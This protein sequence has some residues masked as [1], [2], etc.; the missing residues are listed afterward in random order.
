LTVEVHSRSRE[1]VYTNKEAGFFFTETHL[2][3]R[4][5][6]HG[7]HIYAQEI[8]E[9]YLL[10]ID[11]KVLERSSVNLTFVAPHQFTRV[12]QPGV[13]ETVTL[14][15]SLNALVVELSQL[16]G[17]LLSLSPLFRGAEDS[18][19]YVVKQAEGVLLIASRRNLESD[20]PTGVPAWI[21]ITFANTGDGSSQAVGSLSAHGAFAPAGLQTTLDGRTA[22]VLLVAGSSEAETL[23]LARSVRETHSDLI[24]RRAKRME[25]HLNNTFIRTDHP[26]FDKALHWAILS[27]DA[28][29]MNQTKKGIFAGLPWFNNYWGRDSFI[30]LPGATLVTG[31]FS[32]AKA[33][34]RSFAEWQEV[35]PKSKNYGR[36]PNLVTTLSKS[37]NTADGTA[38]F[39]IALLEYVK[40]SGDLTFA[41]SLFSVVSRAIEGALVHRVDSYGFLTHEDAETWMDAV[42]PEGPWSPRGN[43]AN[44]IQAL[45]HQQ[46]GSGIA[47]ARLMGDSASVT[48]WEFA[49]QKVEAHFNQRFVDRMRGFVY[50]HINIDGSPDHQ[51][52]PNQLFTLQLIDD[53]EVRWKVFRN[54]TQELVYP[55]GVASL[56]QNDE[57]FHPYHHYRPYYVQDAAYHNG[58]VWTW[59]AGPWISHACRF[60]LPDLAFEVTANMVT[61]MLD[62]GAVGTLSELLDAAP[63]PGEHEP[64]LSGTASQAWSLAEFIRSFYQDYLGV[65]TD[66]WE[67]TIHISP[68]LPSTF[69]SVRFRI[70]YKEN[71]I[72][73]FINQNGDEGKV[74][75]RTP[76]IGTI[77]L[78]VEWPSKNGQMR[79]I[80]TT[81]QADQET[82]VEITSYDIFVNG[83][84]AEAY[85]HSPILRKEAGEPVGLA[86]PLVRQDL[87]ALQGPKHRILRHEEVKRENP[88]ANVLIDLTDP[89]G[90]DV[91]T[92]SYVYPQTP[93]LK[94]GS[95]D[96]T[97][98]TLSSDAKNAYISLHFRTLSNPGWHPEYGFQL[99][100]VAIAIDTDGKASSGKREVGMNSQFILDPRYSYEK[101]IYVGGGVRI[102]DATGAILAEYLPADEDVLK[103]L[104]STATRRIEFSLPHD[105]LGRPEPTWRYTVLVGCQDD[106]GGAGIGEF[107]TVREK[108]SEWVG[109]G[110][111]AR[112]DPNVYDMILP[113]Q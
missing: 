78:T 44:D 19:E 20:M 85:L 110:K 27:V 39:C 22:A 10:A 53:V 96:I 64:R 32:D 93:H 107:R 51:V 45:W 105:V 15:D 113:Y 38:W 52:R 17:N 102:E 50:D 109:G 2:P 26:R 89:V 83:K 1:V 86:T 25:R 111:R 34:L 56:S 77:N 79:S 40:A 65:R 74:T 47:L 9:D 101:I 88:E 84:R 99:T 14:L 42:G 100:Y 91:G 30:S 70:P 106:H 90:D 29:I 49:Q 63:R 80:N 73:A 57:N 103:P 58:I 8:L 55:H 31:N 95:L 11:G 6:W 108:A 41:R 3:H 68:R 7:W 92:G 4:S 69:R 104:G 75:L 23:T 21:G 76:S 87:K 81:L 72:S 59:L 37:Y 5:G 13:L 36:I 54:V 67:G 61:Q 18:S 71:W 62:R 94:A 46:L 28:L 24:A 112:R 98:F 97:R 33:I 66:A 12:Y 48:R 43:R 16:K 35:N 60:G 82:I